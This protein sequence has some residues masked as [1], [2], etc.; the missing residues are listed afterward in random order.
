MIVGFLIYIFLVTGC[1]D[2]KIIIDAPRISKNFTPIYTSIQRPQI[3]P[4]NEFL[5]TQT[6]S[7]KENVYLTRHA[8]GRYA[9]YGKTNKL[10]PLVVIFAVS[11]G[12]MIAGFW[13]IVLSLPITIILISTYKFF[14]DDI[15]N[16]IGTMSK[17]KMVK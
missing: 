9:F 11:A 10:H 1:K 4:Y 2:K 3:K 12:G 16:K 14:R 5:R 7:I 15:N 8:L 13:G 6:V 17:K